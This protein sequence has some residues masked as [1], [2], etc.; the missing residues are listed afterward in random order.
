MGRFIVSKHRITVLITGINRIDI[1]RHRIVDYRFIL[2]FYPDAQ[3]FGKGD[4]LIFRFID[5]TD[6]KPLCIAVI[7]H[8]IKHIGRP[9]AIFLM[10]HSCGIISFHRSTF[11]IH[12]SVFFQSLKER[13]LIEID[14]CAALRKGFRL[15]AL[16][17]IQ[18]SR[19]LPHKNHFSASLPET[20]QPRKRGTSQRAA[21]RHN[22]HIIRHCPHAQYGP[23]GLHIILLQQRFRDKVKIDQIKQ[24]PF[25]DM[26]KVFFQSLPF[27]R[28]LH[29]I[30]PVK[31]ITLN[32]MENSYLYGSLS[33]CQRCI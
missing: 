4:K 20:S 33:P 11:H 15:T 30:S 10:L 7:S 23:C 17:R 8:L 5:M 13:S 2:P 21:P 25:D 32:R 3:F 31:P 19:R 6:K 16:R 27:C 24:E 26:F 9:A 18:I 28:C 14:P 1:P 12:F 29:F 22:H